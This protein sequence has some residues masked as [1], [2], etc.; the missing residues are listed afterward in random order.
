MV[1]LLPLTEA[2]AFSVSVA[3]AV[4]RTLWEGGTQSFEGTHYTVENARIYSL[5]DQ[6]PPIYMSGFGPKAATLA[7]RIADGYVNT[8]PDNELVSTFQSNGGAGK[9]VMAMTKMC[10]HESTAEARR[11]VHR[12]WPTH[13]L[14]GELSQELRTPAHFETYEDVIASIARAHVAM[15]RHRQKLGGLSRDEF[16]RL[17]GRPLNSS[18]EAYLREVQGKSD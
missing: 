9:P 4:I 8:A 14:S 15:A 6:P 18:E 11:L 7:G 5:P 10:W 17:K 1:R 13:G 3:V 12:L 16:E 2:D